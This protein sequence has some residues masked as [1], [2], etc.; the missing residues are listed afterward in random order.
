MGACNNPFALPEGLE[1]LLT[2]GFLQE[3][4]QCAVC[5][6]I[7]SSDPFSCMTDFGKFQITH[8]DTQ[9]RTLRDDYGALD[10]ILEF[11]DVPR[12]MIPAQGIHRR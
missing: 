12:P 4:V 7:R 9:G 8:V 5:C 1:D 2:F 6:G 11:S 3:I 10:Y